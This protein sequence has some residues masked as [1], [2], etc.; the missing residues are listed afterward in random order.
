MKSESETDSTCSRDSLHDLESQPIVEM[1]GDKEKEGDAIDEKYHR[2]MNEQLE[3]IKRQFIV[4]IPSS[5]LPSSSSHYQYS[6]SNSPLTISVDNSDSEDPIPYKETTYEELKDSLDKYFDDSE[7]ACSNEL[8]I[9]ITYMK[10]QKNL[11]IQSYLLSQRKLNMLMI[12]AIIISAAVSV[13][14]P[15]L[16]EE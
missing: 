9:L 15:I 14:A 2:V 13:F 1:N 7:N 8:D 10:G 11:Y 16:Q 12:P 3:E 4:N 6:D 5:D